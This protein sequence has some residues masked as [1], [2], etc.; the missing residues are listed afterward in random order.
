MRAKQMERSAWPRGRNGQS[1][2]GMPEGVALFVLLGCDVKSAGC[3]DKDG[4]V[5]PVVRGRDQESPK[6]K[7]L[8]GKEKCSAAEIAPAGTLLKDPG[9]SIRVAQQDELTAKPVGPPVRG[10]TALP[11][12]CAEGE[13]AHDSEQELEAWGGGAVLFKRFSR[14]V[15]TLRSCST[16]AATAAVASSIARVH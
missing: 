3:S 16:P 14:L 9:V 10:V 4:E 12:I 11:A 2:D 1:G 13:R 6:P 7:D 8:L 15:L 5:A